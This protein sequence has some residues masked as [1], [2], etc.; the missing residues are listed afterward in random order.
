MCTI[1][2]VTPYADLLR[3]EVT[4]LSSVD[5]WVGPGNSNGEGWKVTADFIFVPG[6]PDQPG[7]ILDLYDR[8]DIVVGYTDEAK[9]VDAQTP[10]LTFAVPAGASRVVARLVGTGHSF[11]N[12]D[13]CAEFCMMRMDLNVNGVT[14]SVVPWRNDCDENPVSPQYGTWKY[15][16]NG[17][18]P[19]APVL[20]HEVDITDRV[21]M[22]AENV[23][24]FDIRMVDGSVYVNTDPVGW[25]PFMEVT[26]QILVY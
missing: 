4:L 26:L 13:N 24:D 15:S 2:D 17:W 1:V 22:G 10:P 25:D 9:S 6:T 5:T 12:T 20:T 21:V 19:G 14:E 18:C 23:L 3:G 11:G 7:Q 16:R 8:K